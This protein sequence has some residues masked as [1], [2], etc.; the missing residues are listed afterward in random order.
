MSDSPVVNIASRR[1]ITLADNQEVFPVPGDCVADRSQQDIFTVDGFRHEIF[2]SAP[3]IPTE[4]PPFVMVYPGFFEHAA[5]GIGHKFHKTLARFL[6]TAHVIGVATDGFGPEAERYGLSERSDHGLE[7]MG[8]SRSVIIDELVPPES[9]IIFV[10]TSM[11]TILVKEVAKNLSSERLKQVSGGVLN[12]CALVE[13]GPEDDRFAHVRTFSK[14]IFSIVPDIAVE[15]LHT[16]PSHFVG[17]LA[18]LIDSGHLSRDDALSLALLM[19][20]IVTGSKTADIDL[21]LSNFHEAPFGVLI[22]K[23]DPVAEY[24]KWKTRQESHPNLTITALEG[25]S[26]GIVVNPVR[27]GRAAARIL[28]DN[29]VLTPLEAAA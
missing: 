12:A 6:P 14:F 4:N 21:M 3:A 13:Q 29:R 9:P 8:R 15:I 1:S 20:D 17:Q 24:K 2:T 7:A 18:N 16:P 22:G 27:N 26:H 10:G 25:R 19:A 5:H 23:Q 28:Y 11:G